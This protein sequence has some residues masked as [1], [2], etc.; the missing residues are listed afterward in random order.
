MVDLRDT[1]YLELTLKLLQKLCEGHHKNMQLYLHVQDANIHN[2]DLVVLVVEVFKAM[3][4]HVDSRFISIITQVAY[5]DALPHC[6]NVN[7]YRHQA[8]ATLIAFTQGC[9]SNQNAIFQEKV[10]DSIN[11]I[12]RQQDFIHCEAFEVISM[13]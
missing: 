6:A 7:L 2:Y 8:A 9:I 1:F 10:V 12:A 4:E 3:A 5:L 13:Y 11:H